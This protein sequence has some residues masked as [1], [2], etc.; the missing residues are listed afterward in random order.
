MNITFIKLKYVVHVLTGIRTELV[1][2]GDLYEADL[3]NRGVYISAAKTDTSGP[4]P[5]VSYTDEEMDY[6]RELI[7]RDKELRGKGAEEEE[8]A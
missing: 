6:V 8:D 1:R 4:E 3:K 5:T 2:L 7:E